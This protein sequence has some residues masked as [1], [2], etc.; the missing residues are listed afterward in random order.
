MRIVQIV[1]DFGLGGVQKGG[2]VLAKGFGALGHESYA[3]ARRR[4]ERFRSGTHEGCTMLVSGE[5]LDDLVEMVNALS[6]DIV[7]IH[8]SVF[9]WDVVDAYQR[10]KGA[11]LV[12]TPVFGRPP[13]NMALLEKSA[14]CCVGLYT[15]YRYCRWMKVPID[16]SFSENVFFAPITSF[17]A[18]A[19]DRGTK[20]SSMAHVCFGRIGRPSSMKW[21]DAMP[22]V[23]NRLLEANRSY[24]WLSVG[25]PNDMQ[26]AE[27]ISRWGDRFLDFPEI[28]DYEL[29]C[30]K[31]R[32]IDILVF[33]SRYGECFSSSICE[34]VSLGVP[35]VGLLHP[36][37]DAGE[38]EQVIPG[39]TGYL[40]SNIDQ[41]IE[42]SLFLGQ[43]IEERRKL[44]CS[45]SAYAKSQWSMQSV[46]RNLVPIYEALLS[47]HKTGLA[48]HPWQKQAV[49]FA[50]TMP[51]LLLT[52]RSGILRA[53]LRLCLTAYYNYR[54]HRLG[55][56]A[57]ERV[58]KLV[59][60]LK[61]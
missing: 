46:C 21:H 27:M 1:G 18:P 40:T 57:L 32:Q 52:G 43:A 9:E 59:I 19:S 51:A 17:E 26:R 47:N 3:I 53:W 5:S 61:F 22:A 13:S 8:S 44:G 28:A 11:K 10:W 30:E 6:P 36:L 50:E 25:W 20:I 33:A 7:H 12:I 2:I 38:C 45:G 14:I 34:A 55:R 39:V 31:T 58:R 60:A 15:H 16:H 48:E 49:K 37:R 41:L 4:G 56:I 54:L 23:V 24:R 42:R 29:L 35:V